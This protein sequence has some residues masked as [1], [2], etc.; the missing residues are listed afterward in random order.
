MINEFLKI[1]PFEMTSFQFITLILS[2]STFIGIFDT[3]HC[4][5]LEAKKF[6]KEK[7]RN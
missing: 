1:L 3:C 4:Q 2:V 7:S 6:Y 5:S